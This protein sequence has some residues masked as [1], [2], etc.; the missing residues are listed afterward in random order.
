MHSPFKI[1]GINFDHFHMGDLLRMAAEHPEVEIV[2]ICDEHPTRMKEAQQNFE[3][4][5]ERVFTDYRQL[6]ET[7][8]PDLAILCPAA[9]M[10]GE[11]VERVA[12][13]GCDILVEKPFAAS[14]DEADRMIAACETSG[15]RLAINWPLAWMASHRTAKRFV[16]DGRIGDVLEVHYYD[17]N[18]G[19]LHHGADKTERSPEEIAKEKS[20]SWFYK[21]SHGGGSLLDYLGYGTTLGTWYMNGRSPI[22][23]TTVVD[24]AEGLEV[25]EHSVTVARYETGLSK[26]ETRWGTYTDPWT[27][28]PQ[29]PCGFVLIGTRGTI[30][31]YDYDTRIKWQNEWCDSGEWIDTNEILS[32][33][34]NPVQYMVDVIRSGAPIA[35]P[36]SVEISRIG[37]QIVDSA[38]LSAE[39]KRTVPLV[40]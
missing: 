30:S 24:G 9:S 35:G 26:F 7:S 25:D 6:L 5:D 21:K 11:W 16:D 37:Q 2:G 13:F 17:G 12:P 10:H 33:F 23:V 22:E 20:E 19:P 4:P 31:S 38:L 27:H 34:H 8:Q 18:R 39:Q 1:V 3:I 40:G 36:L 29:P 15:S 14:L 32:P 28:Q